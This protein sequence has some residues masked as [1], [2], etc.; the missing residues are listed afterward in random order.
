[1]R[2]YE[3]VD[4]RGDGVYTAWYKRRQTREQA[5]LDAKLATVRRGGESASGVRQELPPNLFRGPVKYQ[6]KFYPNTWKLTVTAGNVA[7]RPL[8]CKGPQDTENEWTILVPVIEVGGEYPGGV[9]AEAESRRLQIIADPN[10]RRL[11]P[12]DNDN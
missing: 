6:K 4:H 5:A 9:F 3:F 12:D 10:R 1:M 11:I 8:A 2:V 7:M